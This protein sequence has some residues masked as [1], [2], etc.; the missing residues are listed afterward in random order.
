ME[1]IVNALFAEKANSLKRPLKH[2][3]RMPV[4]CVIMETCDTAFQNLRAV[5]AEKCSL[6]LQ[7]EAGDSVIL[8]F[9]EHCVGYLH[10]ALNHLRTARIADSPVMLKFSFGEFPLE[11]QMDPAAYTGTLGRGWLQNETKSVAFT[12]YSGMLERRYAFRYLKIQR[13]DNACFPIVL[14]EL[15]ADTVSAV[16]EEDAVPFSTGDT[17]LDQ[18]YQMSLKTLRD[19]EQD[20]FEDGPKRDRRL[21]IGD[22]RLQAMSDWVS[23]Q[24]TDLIKRCLYL[25]A[26]YR[27]PSGLVAPCLFQ[28]SP[29]YVDGWVFIDYSLFFISCLYDHT[30]QF[31]DLPLLEELYPIAEEQAVKALE[32]FDENI[33]ELVRENAHIEWCRGLDKGLAA[34]CVLIYAMKQLAKL[35]ELLEKDNRWILEKVARLAESVLRSHEKEN[36]LYKTQ[37][38]QISW[39]SQ[40]WLVLADILPQS[41]NIE[42]LEALEQ[43]QPNYG[44]HTPYLMH[45]Y[46]EALDSCGMQDKV[47]ENI[48][49]FWGQL[50]DFGF[51]CCPEIFNPNDHFESPYSA[52]E[53]NSACHAWSCTPI[54]WLHK[55]FK[56]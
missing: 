51:N 14:T 25:F 55:Y 31:H 41:E 8:D 43:V 1:P 19:C 23:F 17:L 5:P 48:R 37:N 38:G 6:P 36:G 46:M 33:G 53:A 4:N 24:N 45:Y 30:M 29:P 35:T 15:Y 11:I 10:F 9:G 28:D 54:Y 52:A 2:V 22:L 18:I 40:I 13:V 39:S 34:A 50:V 47:M 26:A 42:I 27:T 32:F 56:K 49:S 7:M 16:S 12:P 21:W 3:Q 44:I 20:V